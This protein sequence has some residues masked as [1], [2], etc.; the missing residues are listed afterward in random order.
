[1]NKVEDVNVSYAFFQRIQSTSGEEDKD[2]F[3]CLH[4]LNDGPVI[5]MALT[6]THSEYKEPTAL[7][8]A[9]IK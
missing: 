2:I 3:A 8:R 1:M 6:Y 5:F 4:L 9:D 7:V